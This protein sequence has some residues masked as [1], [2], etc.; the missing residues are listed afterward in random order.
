MTELPGIGSLAL[1]FDVA[2]LR[3]TGRPTEY[4]RTTHWSEKATQGLR[5]RPLLLFRKQLEQ[6]GCVDRRDVSAQLIQRGQIREIRW[7]A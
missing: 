7:V 6:R 1:I 5:E 4:A 3:E 2:S